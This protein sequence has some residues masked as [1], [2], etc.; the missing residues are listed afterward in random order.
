MNK[1]L[2]GE[3]LKHH[4]FHLEQILR[5][6]NHV[7]SE[8]EE[9]IMAASIEMSHASGEA[10]GMLDNA[11]LKLGTIKDENDEEIQ[12]THPKEKNAL[13]VHK[14]IEGLRGVE[15]KV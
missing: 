8:K 3:E 15:S 7:L 9:L 12:I 4:R 6:R 2:D 5:F 13:R 11:D 1:F 10:F 14:Q